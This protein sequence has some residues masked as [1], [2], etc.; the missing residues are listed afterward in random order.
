MGRHRRTFAML[1]LD[2]LEW[3]ALLPMA[4]AALLLVSELG[5]R[6]GLRESSASLAS[7]KEQTG[8]LGGALLALLGLLLA[9]SFGIV[10]ARFAERKALVLEDAN[11][12][13]TTYLRAEM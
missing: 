7:R 12:I 13:G 9:F 10:E 1:F 3:W 2:T 4:V 11:A 8:I 6:L 5:Y